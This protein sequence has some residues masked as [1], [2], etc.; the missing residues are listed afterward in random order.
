M[1]KNLCGCLVVFLIAASGCVQ[2]HRR[3]VVY[4]TTAPVLV[5]TSERSNVRIYSDRVAVVAEPAPAGIANAE[6]LALADSVRQMLEADP[7]MAE[8]DLQISIYHRVVTLR[9]KVTT[10]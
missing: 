7:S 10:E 9:G 3:Q 1:K 2:S 4:T 8:N 6:D 5:P